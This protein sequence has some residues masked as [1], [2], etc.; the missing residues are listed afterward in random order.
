MASTRKHIIIAGAGL[1]G[2]A[3]AYRLAKDGHIVQL[4]ER[5]KS[6]S[7]AQG[8][9]FIQPNA[10][11]CFLRWGLQDAMEK[12][13]AVIEHNQTRS[14]VDN[15]LLNRDTATEYSTWPL[16]TTTR[17]AIQEVLHK[18]ALEAGAEIHFDAEI[19]N[20]V[21]DENCVSVIMKDGTE[22]KADML[23]AADG[24]ASRLR[25]KILPDS[26]VAPIPAPSTHYPTE[27]TKSSLLSHELT[28]FITE[29]PDA[30][31]AL[32]WAGNRGYAIGKYNPQ[33]EIFSLMYSIP[34]DQD[35]A[36]ESPRLF[37]SVGDP[38]VV[39]DFFQ[40]YCPTLRALTQLTHSVSRW[41]LARLNKLERW[42]SEGRRMVLLGDS[43]HAMM[44]NLAQGF[45]T[46]TE[47]VD[48]LSL[49]LQHGHEEP[50]STLVALWEEFRRPRVSRIQMGSLWNYNLYTSGK[51]PGSELSDEDRMRS[52]DRG[53]A[54]A[55]FNSKPFNKW[56]I[57]YDC[58]TEVNT[59]RR[60]KLRSVIIA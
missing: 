7:I 1:G 47:D 38:K 26:D 46:I 60:S 10:S 58:A 6:L 54:T 25:A 3:A 32:M 11:R 13:T 36:N 43:A 18:E 52:M 14:G 20:V 17:E 34:L 12:V 30:S 49:F 23:L 21:E 33:K 31:D 16:W 37:D 41:R 53:D 28:K 39:Q 4:F 8:A 44:P 50:V 29:E 24:I 27:I 5:T 51:A 9:I 42:S 56:V 45:S 2:L 57:D 48:A 15:A 22:R 40:D 59:H 19:T 55:P 35:A